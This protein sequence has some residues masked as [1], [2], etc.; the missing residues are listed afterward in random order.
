MSP[1]EKMVVARGP[2]IA[3]PIPNTPTPYHRLQR[4]S[5]QSTSPISSESGRRATS[6]VIPGARIDHVPPALPPPRYND[7]LDHGVDLAWTWQNEHLVSGERI[8]A[9]IKPGSS[10]LGNPAQTQLT[11]D[12]DPKAWV[13]SSV[14]HIQSSVRAVTS[15]SSSHFAA[16]TSIS[17]LTGMSPS[18]SGINQT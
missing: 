7:D 2:T 5:S 1:K 3:L 10:L 14:H 18:S 12:D 9:P 8:L 4:Y 17:G 16:V 11:R 6:M 15:P 13:D